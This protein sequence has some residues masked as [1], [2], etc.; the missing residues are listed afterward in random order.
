MPDR[1]QF[2]IAEFILSGLFIGAAL[3]SLVFTAKMIYDA[4]LYNAMESGG[5]TIMLFAA[6]ADPINFG[7]DFMTFPLKLWERSGH[8]TR[9]TTLAAYIG[10]ALF[11][12]GLW[13]NYTHRH[14]VP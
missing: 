9:I 12:A 7:M 5:F 11:L 8:E 6:V 2:S 14:V 10:L 4:E 13:L 3:S 1:P